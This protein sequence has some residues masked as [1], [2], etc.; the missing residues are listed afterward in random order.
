VQPCDGG[1][2]TAPRR[3]YV[4]TL[5]TAR[6]RPPRGPVRRAVDADIRAL[7]VPEGKQAIVATVRVLAG[8][9]DERGLA[10]TARVTAARLLLDALEQLRGVD[11][12]AT[13]A[14]AKEEVGD[15]VEQLAARR[16][17]RTA[18]P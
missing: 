17:R 5:V 6:K 14:P 2:L 10:A 13:P 1:P 9:L 4:A 3:A 15:G 12:P 8:V 16:A 11:S 7:D 18:R